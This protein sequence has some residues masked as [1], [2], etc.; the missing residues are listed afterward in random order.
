MFLIHSIHMYFLFKFIGMI[1]V[2]E[3]MKSLSFEMRTLVARYI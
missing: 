1:P 2:N 3:P